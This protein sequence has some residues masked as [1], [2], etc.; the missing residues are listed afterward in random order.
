M[1][2]DLFQDIL[3]ALQQQ[4]KRIRLPL[5]NPC[6]IQKIVWSSFD[7]LRGPELEFVWEADFLPAPTA[8]EGADGTQQQNYGQKSYCCTNGGTDGTTNAILED[9]ETVADVSCTNSST[10]SSFS[11][12]TGASGTSTAQYEEID[13]FYNNELLQLSGDIFHNGSQFLVSS[14]TSEQCAGGPSQQRLTDELSSLNLSCQT[15]DTLRAVPSASRVTDNANAT[16]YN[17]QNADEDGEVVAVTTETDFATITTTN[18]HNNA[19][20]SSSCADAMVTSCVDS[21]IGG[22]VSIES[23]LSTY[24]KPEQREDEVLFSADDQRCSIKM[25]SSSVSRGDVFGYHIPEAEE[26]IE[27]SQVYADSSSGELGDGH[28]PNRNSD[29]QLLNAAEIHAFDS[30]TV[31]QHAQ[32]VV[33]CCS[34]SMFSSFN[35]GAVAAKNDGGGPSKMGHERLAQF[36]REAEQFA[37]EFAPSDP[38]NGADGL[39]D[40]AFVAKHVLAEQIGSIQFSS[41][42]VLHKFCLVPSRHFCV[43]SYIFATRRAEQSRAVTNTLCAFSVLLPLS[44]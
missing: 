12:N 5:A 24:T 44:Q 31:A 41:N 19:P 36:Y 33:G 16:A 32:N 6:P 4:K 28:S 29:Q 30:T 43:G 10:D 25:R 38:S 27:F 1:E 14:S 34:S 2:A 26:V 42:P 20:S 21:G 9:A 18:N 7:Y 40:E 15:D 23:N 3:S 39:S 35:A 37:A 17:S 11:K 13:E 22:T 8:E